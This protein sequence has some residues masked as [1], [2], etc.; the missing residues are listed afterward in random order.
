MA[1]EIRNPVEV[2][3]NTFFLDPGSRPPPDLAG[4]DGLRHRLFRREGTCSYP[5]EQSEQA[6]SQYSYHPMQPLSKL[7]FMEKGCSDAPCFRAFPFC[8][9][10]RNKKAKQKNRRTCFHR[11]CGLLSLQFSLS[12]AEAAAALLI[13]GSS[14]GHWPSIHQHRRRRHLRQRHHH[15]RC[16]CQ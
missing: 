16:R 3:I 2:I 6:F 14:R 7:R 4:D 5:A 11:S 15:H 13:E 1:C 10:P 9:F 8:L 12:I